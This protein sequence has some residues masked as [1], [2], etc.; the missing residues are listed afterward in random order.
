MAAH[1]ELTA[2][3]NGARNVRQLA[4]VVTRLTETDLPGIAETI[5]ESGD[6][7]AF[8]SFGDE[9]RRI[10]ARVLAL[11]PASLMVVHF[12]DDLTSIQAGV[13]EGRDP[14][15]RHN[16]RVKRENLAYPAT[17]E[18]DKPQNHMTNAALNAGNAFS[19]SSAAGVDLLA[20]VLT[21]ENATEAYIDICDAR[22]SLL[23]LS[24]TAKK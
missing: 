14:I 17:G 10:M 1:K 12:N 19:H 22:L 24:Q 20:M 5:L 16:K 23:S 11:I 21:G 8:M 13:F 18:R 6:K 3:L 15:Q 9:V 4:E 2:A 7:A